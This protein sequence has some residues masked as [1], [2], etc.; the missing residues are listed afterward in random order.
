MAQLTLHNIYLSDSYL[1]NHFNI[2]CPNT[3]K[4]IYLIIY[5]REKEGV[6]IMPLNPYLYYVKLAED[7]KLRKFKGVGLFREFQENPVIGEYCFI[8]DSNFN[9][10]KIKAL[11][12]TKEFDRAY[13]NYLT[14][15]NYE[16]ATY[17]RNAML[18][19]LESIQAKLYGNGEELKFKDFFQ[20]E[21]NFTKI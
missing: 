21:L 12:E 17:T 5:R 1:K 10:Q 19:W 2:Y 8:I 13:K 18:N 20:Q 15:N 11:P 14:F 4:L 3:N 9:I 16:D 6:I 7:Y